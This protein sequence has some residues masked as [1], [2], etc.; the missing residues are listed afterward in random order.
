MFCVGGAV[1]AS[2]SI[3]LFTMARYVREEA[4]FWPG[5]RRIER[6]TVTTGDGAF[7]DATVVIEAVREYPA[8]IPTSLKLTSFLA[9]CVGQLFPV[10]VL[11]AAFGPLFLLFERKSGGSTVSLVAT[12]VGF[13]SWAAASGCGWKSTIA[14]LRGDAPQADK[15]L[16][17]SLVWHLLTLGAMS[18]AVLFDLVRPFELRALAGAV[19][20]LALAALAALQQAL[21]RKHQ[22]RLPSANVATLH[23]AHHSP[24]TGV[25]I[26]DDAGPSVVASDDRDTG[27]MDARGQRP[28]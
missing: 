26:E 20:F 7:R 25:R 28:R 23:N 1:L 17:K 21:F 14:V 27:A 8:G 5:C 24:V 3:P 18:A 6:S 15:T 19:P 11:V 16:H 9:L 12:M 13:G 4:L 10:L 2:L 22:R